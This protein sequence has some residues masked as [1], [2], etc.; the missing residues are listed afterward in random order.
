M[1]TFHLL[2]TPDILCANDIVSVVSY[3]LVS[4]CREQL[5]RTGTEIDQHGEGAQVSRYPTVN[6]KFSLVGRIGN[7]KRCCVYESAMLS[8][9]SRVRVPVQ[10]NALQISP[11]QKIKEVSRDNR[12]LNL[13][14]ARIARHRDLRAFWT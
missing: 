8:T 6:P 11:P 1:R 14:R 12:C 13:F 10:W 5:S 7:G 2:K 3:F 4:S 9:P